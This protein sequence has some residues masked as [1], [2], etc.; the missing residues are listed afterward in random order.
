MHLG[1]DEI[2][3]LLVSTVTLGQSRS[4]GDDSQQNLIY[5]I[6]LKQEKTSC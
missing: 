2:S 5:S 1:T 4:R 3:K 6:M